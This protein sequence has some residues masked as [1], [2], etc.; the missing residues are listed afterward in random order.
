MFAKLSFAAF[1]CIGLASTFLGLHFREEA[2]RTEQRARAAAQAEQGA[3][4]SIKALTPVLRPGAAATPLGQVQA[5]AE[6]V[7][8]GAASATG[9]SMQT[10]LAFEPQSRHP[11]DFLPGA[12]ALRTSTAR[13]KGTYTNLPGLVAYLTA[14][15]GAAVSLEALRVHG[16]QFEMT[17]RAWGA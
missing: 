12:S 13:V 4:T 10:P 2:E 9:V 11:A 1:I 14:L 7:L 15:Q 16:T 6:R 8:L 5:A 17:L 3:V